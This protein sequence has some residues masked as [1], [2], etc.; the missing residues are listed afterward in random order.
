M[1]NR[2]WQ[3]VNWRMVFS[4]LAASILFIPFG[5]YV[6]LWV[7]IELMRVIAAILMLTAVF[8]IATGRSFPVKKNPRVGAVLKTSAG[9]WA[10]QWRKKK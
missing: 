1:A 3:Q 2:V 9:L 7:Q 6:L 5:Q 4:I 10:Q 8:L